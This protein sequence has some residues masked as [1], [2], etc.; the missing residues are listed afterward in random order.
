MRHSFPTVVLLLLCG[1]IAMPA[2]AIEV[3]GRIDPEEWQGAQHITDFRKVE[4]LNG[5]P[6]SLATEGFVLATPQGLAVAFRNRHPDSVPLSQQ[7]VQRDFEDQV[8]RVTVMVDFDGDGRT[9]YVFTVSATDGVYDAILSNEHDLN[10]DWDGKWRHA[11]Q[12]D[13]DGWSVE[14]L[15]PWHIAPMRKS[16]SD[17][18]VVKVYLDRVIGYTGER[19]A[20]PYASIQRPR[21][22]SEFA[23]IELTNYGQQLLAITPFVSAL[24]DNV[25]RDNRLDGGLDLFWKPSGQTQLTATVNPDFGQVES[26]DLIVNFN[27]T[28]IFIRDKRPFFTENQGIF[29]FTTPSDDSQLLYTRRVGGP[30]DDGDGSGDIAAALKLNGSVGSMKYGV[31][32]ADE[33]GEAGRTFSALRLVRDFETQ[34]LGIMATNVERPFYDREASVVGIDHDWR[35]TARWNVRTRLV[36]SDIQQAGESV[37][38]TGATLITDYE[39][40]QRWRAQFVGMHFGDELQLNDAGYLSRNNYNYAHVQLSRRFTEL[41]ETS[42]YASK[43]WRGRFI[44]TYD[45]HGQ[46]LNHQLR[47]TRES[48]WRNGSWE[49]GQI[50]INSA[51][52]D[53]LVTRGNGAMNRPPSF[54]SYFTIERPRRGNWSYTTEAELFSGKLAGNKVLGY[55]FSIVPTYHV[56]DAFNVYVG[57][58]V[59]YNPDWIIWEGG[60]LV[61][62]FASRE[63]H[64]DTGINWIATPKQELRLK[65]QAI[66]INAK[67]RQAYR[68]DSRGNAIKSND[69]V[70]DFSVANL[71]V[72]L[73]YRYEL[74]PLSYLYVV[75]GRGGYNEDP[76]AQNLGRSLRDSFSLRDEE[77]LL[78]KLSYR[79]EP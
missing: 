49:Y 21:F 74:A 42:R 29:E 65:L 28:E 68:I 2:L 76:L 66:G 54:G 18:R 16:T 59:D 73:R 27:A 40:N 24:R 75:Y 12:R 34:N 5:D 64:F 43:D 58:Y 26:D 77:Q 55:S 17:Q 48:R 67:L 10:A 38:D 7:R 13:Q 14:V 50:V 46:L 1:L 19:S 11:V 60:N 47:L 35:P 52:V 32:A 44:E 20:W 33:A 6:A 45:D 31:F 56:S 62:S 39:W 71:G 69:P 3:D 15:L 57:G 70:D 72:Q 51:G 22:L 63:T 23:P 30:A 37:R 9:G 79:F 8:D 53:D 25:E 61:G 41:P 4:P 36:G 78:I